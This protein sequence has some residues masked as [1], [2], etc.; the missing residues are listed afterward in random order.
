MGKLIK[1][2]GQTTVS[3]PAGNVD[4]YTFGEKFISSP[5]VKDIKRANPKWH[6]TPIGQ[7]SF[8][9]ATTISKT[10]KH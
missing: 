7:K 10:C 3:S 5:D 6:G 1:K 9:G 2:R 4:F 8:I